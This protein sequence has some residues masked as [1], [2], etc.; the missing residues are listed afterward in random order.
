V[1]AQTVIYLDTIAKP[2][3]G[4]KANVVKALAG[5]SLS[6]SFCILIPNEVKAHK[7]VWH[8]EQVYVI[9]GK[10]VMRLGDKNISIKSGD[11]IF[12]P[13]NTIHAVTSMGEVPL[14]VLSV[15]S[16]LFDGS[17]RVMVSE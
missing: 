15:Q 12:I 10:G 8:S 3:A 1:K 5:D 13:K 16:P 11:L 9:Q 6:S 7:H 14:K 17:D 2:V 4:S